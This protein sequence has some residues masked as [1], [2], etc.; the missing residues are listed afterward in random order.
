MTSRPIRTA[1]LGTV[2]AAALSAGLLTGCSD[3]ERALNQGGDT[4]CKDYVKQDVDTKRVTITK[5]VKQQSG[6]DHEPAGTAVDA[7]MAAADFLCANQ[8]NSDTP[9]KNANLTGILFNQ[10]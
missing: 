5:F 4:P 6:S 3:V 7:S 2:V 9:I 10:Q 1:L 8:R